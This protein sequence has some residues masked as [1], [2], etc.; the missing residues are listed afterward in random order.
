MSSAKKVLSTLD[1]NNNNKAPQ[2]LSD[3]V[4]AASKVAAYDYERNT[5]WGTKV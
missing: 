4:E 5:A 2:H 1:E 3:A